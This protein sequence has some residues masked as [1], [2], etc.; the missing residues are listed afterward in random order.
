MFYLV[1]SSLQD[2]TAL[3][4]HLKSK[5][6]YAAFHYIS[7]HSSPYYQ[8]KHDGRILKETDRYSDCLL[9]LPLYYELSDSEVDYICQEVLNYYGI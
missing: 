5:G 3:V 8:N 7:L 4:A 1:C 9:R 6:I 2:R